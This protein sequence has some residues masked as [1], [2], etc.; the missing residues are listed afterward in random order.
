MSY[1]A[2]PIHDKLN[3]G[4]AR[5]EMHLCISLD[6]TSFGCLVDCSCA[7]ANTRNNDMLNGHAQ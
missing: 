3:R 4:V 2:N 7:L 6:L 1:A 5:V